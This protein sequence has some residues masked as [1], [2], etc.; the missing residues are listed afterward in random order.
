LAEFDFVKKSVLLR[1]LFSDLC[2]CLVDEQN[3]FEKHKQA[4]I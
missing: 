2:L 3:A 4:L 1:L